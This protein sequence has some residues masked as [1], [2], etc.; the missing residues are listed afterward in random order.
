MRINN[1]IAV[2]RG[3]IYLIIVQQPSLISHVQKKYNH[4]GKT[5]FS[6]IN[7]W[8]ALSEIF[9]IIL[10]DL[11]TESIILIIDALD[12]CKTDLPKLLDLIIQHS[13]LSH[14]K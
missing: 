7:A 8:V 1:A 2:L 14:V 10:H 4:A 3:L 11:R 12:K 5:L 9:T 6:D 13:L